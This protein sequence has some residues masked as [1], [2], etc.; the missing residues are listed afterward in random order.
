[1]RSRS[2]KW[3]P[4]L[5]ARSLID[6]RSI[7]CNRFSEACQLATRIGRQTKWAANISV[8]MLCQVYDPILLEAVPPRL[9]K[10]AT[11]LAEVAANHFAI[12]A[13][14][15]GDEGGHRASFE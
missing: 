13:S 2:G 15:R 12:I 6:A 5:S 9:V 10:A 3:R 8:N 4:I 1:M 11:V 14:L 7:A